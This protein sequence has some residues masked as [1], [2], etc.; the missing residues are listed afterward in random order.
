MPSHERKTPWIGTGLQLREAL[1]MAVPDGAKSALRGLEG[2]SL[3]RR[4]SALCARHDSGMEILPRASKKKDPNKYKI[5][6]PEV[7]STAKSTSFDVNKG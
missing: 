6:L 3:G 1:S 5:F 7:E 2:I 4:L